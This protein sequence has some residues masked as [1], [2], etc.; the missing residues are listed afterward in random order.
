M[1]HTGRRNPWP[2]LWVAL[3]ALV[4]GLIPTRAA[5]TRAPADT[6]HTYLPAITH[7]GV[8][9]LPLVRRS[10]DTPI[11]IIANP[12]FENEAWFTDMYGNQHP[13]GWLFFAPAAGQTMPF[14]TKRQGSNTV[15][16]ISG[17]QGE[18]VHKYFWQLPEEERLGG[19][20]GL[21]LDGQITYKVFSDHIPHA[22]KLSQVLTYTPG[23]W[24]RVTG[25]IVGETQ[26]FACSG[27]G[28]LEDD[29]FIGSVQLGGAADTRFYAVMHNH[30]D[31]PGN[32]RPWNKFSVAAQAPGNGQLLLVVIAQS[33]WGCPVDFFIDHFQAYETSGP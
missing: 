9:F 1:T 16:A 19:A 31:V 23:R 13:A 6:T 7:T 14:P 2:R 18:Y 28:V 22:L 15:P 21:I 10:G 27:N 20:R 33:N 29:H 8:T 25:Y 26:P 5:F 11:N 30:H 17:G 4:L 32:T 3:L 24:V 12:S